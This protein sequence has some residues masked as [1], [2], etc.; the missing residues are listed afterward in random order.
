M[1]HVGD[2]E[3]CKSFADRGSAEVICARLASE[4]VPAQVDALALAGGV[5][6]EYRVVV[7]STLVHRAR[8]VLAQLPPSDAELE[9][10]A[11]G[12]LPAQE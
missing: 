4:G 3:L 10:L 2:W 7:P 6:S 9:Y 11:T 8:W 1:A 12:R 5:Q